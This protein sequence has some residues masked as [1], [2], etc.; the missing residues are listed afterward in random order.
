MGTRLRYAKL[1]FCIVLLVATATAAAE[2][3]AQTRLLG[4]SCS[5]STSQPFAAWGDYASYY[6]APNGGLEGGSTGWSL[7]GGASVVTGNEPF[8]GSGTRSLSLPSGSSATSPTTCIGTLNMALRMFV[9]DSGGTDSGLRVRVY[10]YGLLN[11]LL[12]VTDYA[13]F[14]PGTSWQPSSKVSTIGGVNLLVPLLGS[15]SARVK[16]TPLGSG[17]A[18]N[19]DDLYVDPLASRCC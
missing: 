11:S 9:E 10:W 14:A 4:L 18:W 2:A 13:T 7:T 15:T 19:V 16:L 17:S 5:G 12:G 6:L 8:L 1:V 3:S